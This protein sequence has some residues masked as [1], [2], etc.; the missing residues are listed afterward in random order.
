[1]YIFFSNKAEFL[2]YHRCFLL[3]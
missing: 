3:A 1:M 2:Q